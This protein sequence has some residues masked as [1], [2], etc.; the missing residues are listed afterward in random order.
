MRKSILLLLACACASR[1]PSVVVT[2]QDLE[3]HKNAV[4]IDAHADTTEA[5]FYENYD[6]L[7]LHADRHVDLPRMQEG[8]LDAEFFSVF[9]H[10]ESVDLTQF[11]P[12]P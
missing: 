8:G 3:F 2:P 1:K 11:F 10:P 4:V 6:L 7:S 9:V 12:P 5:M